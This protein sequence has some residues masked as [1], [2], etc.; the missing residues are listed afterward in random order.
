MNFKSIWNLIRDTFKE[1]SE[2]RAPR[3]AAALSYYTIFSLAPL[4]V[5][6]IAIAGFVIGNNQEIRHQI[7]TQVQSAVSSDASKAVD[8][9]IANTS[10][11]R[12]GIIATVIGVVTLLMGATGVFGQLQDSLNTIWGVQARKTGGI[13]GMIKD[14]SLSFAM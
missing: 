12:S 11:P 10:K 5:L 13:L 7:V 9:L 3:L 1:W 2:D 4:L 14:R 6:I 8:Q